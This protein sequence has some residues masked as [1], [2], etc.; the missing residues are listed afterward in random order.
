MMAFALLES[1][2]VIGFLLLLSAVLP[3]SWLKDGFAYKGFVILLIATAEALLIQKYLQHEFP[4][5][6]AWILGVL[7][8]ILLITI[9]LM[10]LRYLPKVQDVLLKIED[11]FLI[12]TF[13]YIPIGLL[14]LIVVTFRNLF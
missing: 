7:G 5:A 9:L 3:S 10:F 2:A 4:S 12:L 13:V 1:L 11:R 8:P 14:C 6:S